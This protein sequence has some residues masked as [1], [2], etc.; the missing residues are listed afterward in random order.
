MSLH[1]FLWIGHVDSPLQLFLLKL[2]QLL[3]I[4]KLMII[5]AIALKTPSLQL[6]LR[7]G[8]V[9]PRVRVLVECLSIIFINVICNVNFS[10]SLPDVNKV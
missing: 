8:W 3:G 10:F 4:E 7:I 6:F 9:T 2:I 5:A 1:V